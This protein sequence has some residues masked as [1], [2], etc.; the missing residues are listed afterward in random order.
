LFPKP[1][2][3]YV[4]LKTA[5]S[6]KADL[7]IHFFGSNHVVAYAAENYHGH[8]MAVTIN[9]GA[10]SSVCARSF[11][12]STLFKR[13]LDSVQSVITENLQHPLKFTH[14]IIGGFSAGYGAVRAL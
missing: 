7:L 10:G 5:K 13:L 9:L 11:S 4:P 2:D 14:I 1:V 6:R 8:L 3:V 12:D